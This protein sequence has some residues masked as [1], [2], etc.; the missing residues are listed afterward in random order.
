MSSTAAAS[1]SLC[2]VALGRPKSTTGQSA[3][4]KRPS[5]VPPW[6]ESSGSTPV[7]A[8]IAARDDLVDRPGRGQEGLARDLR[9]DRRAR[10]RRLGGAADQLDQVV[11]AVEVVEADVELGAGAAGDDVGRLARGLDRGDFEVGGLEGVVAV[12]E[13]E[14]L[15]RGEHPRQLRHRIVGAVRV[16]DV[17]LHAGHRDP[18]VD[19]AAPADL[20]DV[21][22]PRLRGRLADQDHVGP[23]AALRHPL[24]QR[25]RAVGRRAFLVAG[26]DQAERAGMLGTSAQ[27]A[28]KAAIP[29]FMSTAPRP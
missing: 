19:R 22:E 29:P 18:H 23:D 1:S 3:I 27:A 10:R 5:E 12:V 11:A 24:H 15:E 9:L 6:V 26:D 13:L 2:M 21:A 4:R 14:R 25:R 17:A 7:S 8:S 28:T 20:D 16:G